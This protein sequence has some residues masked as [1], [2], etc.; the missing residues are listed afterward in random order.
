[1]LQALYAVDGGFINW[2]VYYDK[3]TRRYCTRSQQ[4]RSPAKGL[5]AGIPELER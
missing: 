3:P 1:L 4:G 2:E 5:V